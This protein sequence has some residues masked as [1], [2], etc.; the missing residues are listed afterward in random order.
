[1]TEMAEHL[2]AL[3]R[4]RLCPGMESAPVVGAVEDARI[5]LMGQAPGP[6]EPQFGKPFAWTAGKTLFKWFYSIGVEE[7]VFRQR[8]YMGAVVRC[9]P[10]KQANQQ[11]DRKPGKKEIMACRSHF[12][13]EFAILK[14]ELMLLVGKMAIEQFLP[15]GKL[16]GMVGRAFTLN[17]HG[18]DFTAI[19][20]P[21]PS[22]LSRWIQSD[23]GKAL[24]RQ[25]LDLIQNHST[26][27]TVFG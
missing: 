22:G 19:P 13:R 16:D 11:G 24:T 1:M 5:F 20:L 12:D 15:P 21:H 27:R 23:K 18:H 26:W 2:Q 14:P 9:F 10:G 7:E 3:H 17:H 4:C 8:V 6:K 25:A